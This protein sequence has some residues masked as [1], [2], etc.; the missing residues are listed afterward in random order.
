M[1]AC[2]S[3]FPTAAL[4]VAAA[5]GESQHA[6]DEGGAFGGCLLGGAF[7]LGAAEAGPV[8]SRRAFRRLPRARFARL[9]QIDDLGHIPSLSA[10]G[11]AGERIAEGR[12][13]ANPL[14]QHCRVLAVAQPHHP[15]RLP[16]VVK[17]R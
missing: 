6:A 7:G 9:P 17:G 10:C 14:G 2:T 15:G 13:S 1:A 5:A 12:Q 8:L 3:G 11:F 16:V 4:S